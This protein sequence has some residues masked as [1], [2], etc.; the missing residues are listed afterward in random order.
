MEMPPGFKSE[1]TFFKTIG[2]EDVDFASP[3]KL[4]V[5]KKEIGKIEII[6]QHG[7]IP[8]FNVTEPKM[9]IIPN[10]GEERDRFNE[11]RNKKGIETSNLADVLNY[12]ADTYSDDFYLPGMDYQD[13]INDTKELGGDQE[14]IDKLK[15]TGGDIILPGTLVRAP[16]GEMAVFG[17]FNTEYDKLMGSKM[18]LV[19]PWNYKMSILLLPKPKA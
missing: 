10:Q 12:I 17:L 9:V 18:F 7:G 13:W 11:W 8:D 3:D 14:I 19:G 5:N 4:E 6:K 2:I 15:K 16:D 1:G